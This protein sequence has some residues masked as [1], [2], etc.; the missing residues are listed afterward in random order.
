VVSFK[1]D[2]TIGDVLK[3]NIIFDGIVLLCAKEVSAKTHIVRQGRERCR[4][5]MIISSPQM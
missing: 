3:A 1:Q 2:S 5:K 4:P